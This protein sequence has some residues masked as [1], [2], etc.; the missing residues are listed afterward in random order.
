M[1]YRFKRLFLCSMVVFRSVFEKKHGNLRPFF[2]YRMKWFNRTG[3]QCSRSGTSE[4]SRSLEC[5]SPPK[6]FVEC[7]TWTNDYYFFF[8]LGNGG[9]NHPQKEWSK[10]LRP[11]WDTRPKVQENKGVYSS[12]V[13]SFPRDS[14]DHVWP[15]RF[16]QQ[17]MF[18]TQHDNSIFQWCLGCGW[19]FQLGYLILSNAV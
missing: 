11:N 3:N 15:R 6:V 12:G 2:Q 14:W 16:G 4:V 5:S 13:S 17:W 9:W 7:Q 1:L 19:I 10:H 18:S 8:E